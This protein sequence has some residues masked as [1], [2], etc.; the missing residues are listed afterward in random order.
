[1]KAERIA[2]GDDQLPDADGAGVAEL[3]MGEIV[4]ME[5]KDGQ[6]AVGIVAHQVGRERPSVGE[7]R[8]DRG[9]AMHDMAVGEHE[10][11]GR[12]DHARAGAERYF[13]HWRRIGLAAL[14]RLQVDD[15]RRNA[16]DRRC[17]CL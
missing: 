4:G 16:I 15:R 11:V 2:D 7:S 14:P 12:E 10:A 17:N 5:A 3:G 13:A 6:I 1:M 8:L 9:R